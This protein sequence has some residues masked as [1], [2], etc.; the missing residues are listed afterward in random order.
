MAQNIYD[1]PTFFEGYSSLPRSE[2]GLD[3]AP[4]WPALRAMLPDLHGKRVLDLGCGFGWFA[5][6]ARSAGASS[7]HGIDVSERMLT[8]ARAETTDDH[9]EYSQADLD[10]HALRLDSFDVVYS[11]LALHYLERLDLVFE[12][13][14]HALSAAGQLVFSVEH[15]MFTAPKQA[16]FV[17]HPAGH[18]SWPVDAY[19]AEGPRVR[20]WLAPGVIKQHRTLETY[21]RLLRQAGFT[22]ADLREWGPSE[23]DLAEHPAWRD[24]QERPAFLLV[25]CRRHV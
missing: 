1:D 9:V 19:F 12:R 14:F 3:A 6:W 8:R 15:P 23:G 20:D 24:E 4:E 13:V 5:R 16:G 11:S 7:V 2:R 10:Q 18:S 17:V 22:L 21:L 25:S